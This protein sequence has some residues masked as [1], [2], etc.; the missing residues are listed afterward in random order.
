MQS[1]TQTIIF[2]NTKKF[3]EILF[4]LLRESG[5]KATIIFGNMGPEERDEYIEKFRTGQV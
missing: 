4:N 2:V 3:A 5:Y 1:K